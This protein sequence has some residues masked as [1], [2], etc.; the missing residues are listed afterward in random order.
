MSAVVIV[1]T[2][3][4]VRTVEDADFPPIGRIR[5]RNAAGPGG[6]DRVPP[7][8]PEPERG[9]VQGGLR[10]PRLTGAAAMV[11][12]RETALVE[13]PDDLKGGAGVQPAEHVSGRQ[14]RDGRR[15]RL[16]ARRRSA[17]RAARAGLPGFL[18]GK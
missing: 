6:P 16:A 13:S 18:P 17:A 12:Q 1:S 4:V 9:G 15:E 2:V 7:A 3:V 14:Q 11:G 5:R 8:L 10:W